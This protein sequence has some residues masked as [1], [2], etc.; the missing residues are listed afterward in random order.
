MT[1]VNDR[2]VIDAQ[3]QHG[4]PVIRGTRVPVVRIVGGLGERPSDHNLMADG[5]SLIAYDRPVRLSR[6]N[7]NSVKA[8]IP[9]SASLKH[10]FHHFAP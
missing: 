2:I 5:G 1:H 3:I 4:K 9:T 6:T 8:D 10:H 7:N